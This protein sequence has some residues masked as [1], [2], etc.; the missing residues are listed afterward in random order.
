MRSLFFQDNRSLWLQWRYPLR[1]FDLH[2]Q[3]EVYDYSNDTLWDHLLS[4]DTQKSMTTVSIV[5]IRVLIPYEIICSPSR[6]TEDCDY[7]ND[8]LWYHLISTDKQT[9]VTTVTIPMRSFDLPPGQQK[10]VTTVTIPYEII[11]SPPRT[12][13]VCDYSNDTLWDQCSSWTTEVYDYSDDTLSNNCSPSWT[14][15]WLQYRYPMRSLPSR[16]KQKSVS[17]VMTPCEIFALN[18]QAEVY[19]YSDDTLWDLC[20]PW[21][22]RRLWLWWYLWDQLLSLLNK[23][24]SMTTLYDQ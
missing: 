19:V 9:S 2:R 13:E 21:S 20:S 22:S 1:S 4:T 6:T 8:T 11:A 24:K 10:S 18:G 3:A 7:G 5:Y 12:T 14:S 15:L 23:Q 16:G 17:T